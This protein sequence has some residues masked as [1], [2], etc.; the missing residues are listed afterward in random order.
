MQ[1]SIFNATSFVN[2]NLEDGQISSIGKDRLALIPTEV[3]SLLDASEALAETGEEWGRRHGVLLARVLNGNEGIETMAEH[4]GGTAAILGM[5]QVRIE[6]Q[7]DA[8]LFKVRLAASGD[9]SQGRKTLI[10]GF[11][12]GYVN[13]LA[14]P[15][16]DILY[17]GHIEK[18]HYFWAGNQ[19]AVAKIRRLSLSGQQ[20][21]AA[22]AKLPT[23]RV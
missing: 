13:E 4:L 6:I 10:S 7:G 17:V 20:A 12:K 1:N 23:R 15:K 14:Q 2:F 18:D 8:L 16:L 9:V 21:L 19:K 11:L 3:L 5:G 22:I